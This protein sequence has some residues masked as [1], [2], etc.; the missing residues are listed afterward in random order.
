MAGTGLFPRSRRLN[1][2][3]W[4]VSTFK[5]V[6]WLELACFHVQGGKMAGTGLFLHSRR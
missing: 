4:P 3:N 1:G 5:A 6:K 2:W